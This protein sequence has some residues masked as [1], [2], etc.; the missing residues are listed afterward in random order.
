[1]DRN[2]AKYRTQQVMTA[3]P[4]KLVFM[5]YD[6]AILSLREAIAAIEKGE[7]E[8]RW[9]ANRRAIEILENVWSMLDT[10]KG[11]E[12]AQSLDKL[13]MTALMR[14]P[15]VD[16][17]NDPKAAEDVIRILE[18]LRDAWREIAM[19]GVPAGDAAGGQ[20]SAPAPQPTQER[21]IVSA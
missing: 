6:K 20:A 5:L 7:I 19:K 13:L 2:V 10:D 14:L 15:D 12:I 11:G 1:M 18:P 21:T 3:S 8:A 4:A 9:K 16:I 17:Q